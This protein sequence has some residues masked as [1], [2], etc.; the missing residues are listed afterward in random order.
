MSKSIFTILLASA[1]AG[2]VASTGVRSD[3]PSAAVGAR[4]P[5]LAGHWQG[6]ISETGGWY[7]QGSVPLDL[8]IAPDGTWSGRVGKAR[9]SGTA[10]LKGRDLELRGTAHQATNPDEPVYLRLTGDDTRR[11]GQ[12]RRDFTGGDTHASV[13]LR[14]TG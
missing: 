1:I 2:C 10:R 11:W 14:K 4:V 3:D 13:S 7:H 5:S 6:V 8:T 12:T 9:A